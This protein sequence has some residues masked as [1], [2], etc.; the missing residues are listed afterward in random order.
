MTPNTANTLHSNPAPFDRSK[1]PADTSFRNAVKRPCAGLALIAPDSGPTRCERPHP[2]N[3][4]S[5][6]SSAR[7]NGTARA[8]SVF[9][10]QCGNQRS[11]LAQLP[12]PAG[13]A[14]SNEHGARGTGSADRD[15]H[16]THRAS[17]YEP[18][19]EAARRR[20]QAS[21][22]LMVHRGFLELR[23]STVSHRGGGRGA[24]LE[25]L[26]P[27]RRAWTRAGTICGGASRPTAAASHSFLPPSRR[28]AESFVAFALVRF[29]H[30]LP[31]LSHSIVMNRPHW[32][33]AAR[34]TP[35]FY[36]F[37]SPLPGRPAR[38]R[39]QFP[40]QAGCRGAAAEF[41]QLR[42]FSP[43]AGAVAYPGAGSFSGSR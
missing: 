38:N 31:P 28:A 29:G 5:L 33:Q 22:R 19:F 26:L 27:M 25:N 24:V 23:G 30:S 32:R 7:Q 13:T 41:P 36:I 14:S 10:A 12:I 17:A 34:A 21:L 37:A 42:R 4:I 2:S 20:P 3:S 18:E 9:R 39:R 43:V 35:R 40:D 6:R 16:L 11:A 1:T 15:A 8:A